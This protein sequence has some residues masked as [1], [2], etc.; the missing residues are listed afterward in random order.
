MPKVFNFHNLT[1]TRGHMLLEIR[2]DIADGVLVLS[3]R[4]NGAG[5]AQYPSLIQEAA[6]THDEDWLADRLLGIDAFV[7]FEVAAG[8]QKAVRED[9][10]ILFAQNEFNRF[11][12]RGLC[13]HAIAS[14]HKYVRVYRARASAKPRPESEAK[15]GMLLNPQTILKDLRDHLATEVEFGMPQIFSGLSLELAPDANAV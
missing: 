3:K 5:N 11:Y 9:A 12:C 7:K 4:F 6:I 2:Q 1:E 10:H 15:I 8:K 13:A 14:E